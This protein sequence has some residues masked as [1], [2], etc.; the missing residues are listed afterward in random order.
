MEGVAR[1]VSWLD[2]LAKSQ[3]GR[4]QVVM[5]DD[6]SPDRTGNVLADLAV[7]RPW[8]EA[9]SLRKRQGQNGAIL[10]GLPFCK[11]KIV[12]IIDGDGDYNPLCF[13]EMLEKIDGVDMVN[14]SRI[15][16]SPWARS[17][18][19]SVVRW[20]L[21]AASLGDALFDPTSPVKL[22][23]KDIVNRALQTPLSRTHFHESLVL[24]SQRKAEINI[25]RSGHG[26]PSRYTFSTLARLWTSLV[27]G[28]VRHVVFGRYQ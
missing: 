23:H 25:T 12:G 27:F 4:L 9:V 22:V 19:T 8:L 15:T 3:E 14:G 7:R 10:A 20:S 13:V 17:V 18:A 26:P 5:V 16:G 28:C 21:N 2:L 24:V 6:A 11:G 1:F